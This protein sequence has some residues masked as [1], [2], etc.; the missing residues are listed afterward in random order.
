MSFDLYRLQIISH[1]KLILETS[2]YLCNPSLMFLSWAPE[3]QTGS[4]V[5]TLIAAL[6][7][8][9]SDICIEGHQLGVASCFL[10]LS[11]LS[12]PF[13]CCLIWLTWP[14]WQRTWRSLCDVLRPRTTL[15]G[16]SLNLPPSVSSTLRRNC[17]WLQQLSTGTSSQC[18]P[19]GWNLPVVTGTRPVPECSTYSLE[20]SG[21]KQI[22]LQLQTWTSHSSNRGF[23]LFAWWSILF[24]PLVS[25]GGSGTLLPPSGQQWLE[26]LWA[27][28]LFEVL[29]AQS[30][31]SRHQWL[32]PQSPASVS[33][34][35]A[36]AWAAALVGDSSW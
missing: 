34:H 16:A 26:T 28:W 12:I 29:G 8:V 24:W 4:E 21:L 32:G 35:R 17:C 19:T 1:I 14:V 25:L 31:T 22:F 2:T 18:A 20:L 3:H 27:C 6:W 9:G 11:T 23:L 15:E 13:C 5:L 30:H 36:E 10:C 7:L 33:L